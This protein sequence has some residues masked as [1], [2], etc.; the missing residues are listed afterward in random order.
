MHSINVDKN[1][2]IKILKENKD[3]HEKLYDEAVIGYRA[4]VCEKLEDALRKASCGEKYITN[5]EMSVPQHYLKDYDRIIGMLELAT[6]KEIELNSGE[7][8]QYVNDEWHWAGTTKSI[9]TMY[10]SKSKF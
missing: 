5:L 9:N 1:E 4:E 2:L 10:A 7:Y 3:K 6:E 8:D